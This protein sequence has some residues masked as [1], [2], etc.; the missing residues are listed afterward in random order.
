MF[1]AS[2]QDELHLAPTP[3]PTATRPSRDEKPW[4]ILSTVHIASKETFTF[5]KKEKEKRDTGLMLRHRMH[6]R[7]RTNTDG[8]HSLCSRTQPR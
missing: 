2:A 3:T 8:D 1:P 5:G 4:K 7:F 6:T